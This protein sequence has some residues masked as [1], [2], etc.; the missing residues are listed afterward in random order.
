M[1]RRV[2]SPVTFAL[3]QTS[4]AGGGRR[5][6]ERSA[7]G[8]FDEKRLPGVSRLSVWAARG[9]DCALIAASVANGR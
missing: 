9:V 7:N 2:E 6:E 5:R 1:Q 8:L 4:C 3:S